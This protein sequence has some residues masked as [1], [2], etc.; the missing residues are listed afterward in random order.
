METKDDIDGEPWTKCKT[1]KL[2]KQH[3]KTPSEEEH[4]QIQ[5]TD[6]NSQKKDIDEYIKD[7]EHGDDF[8]NRETMEIDPASQEGFLNIDMDMIE[9]NPKLKHLNAKDQVEQMMQGEQLFS[10]K[11]DQNK[12]LKFIQ[13]NPS[14]SI[15]IENDEIS[16]VKK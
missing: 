9:I 5:F 11:F 1:K 16:F 4:T 13:N 14:V 2:Y 3:K 10:F 8:Y 12:M 15:R 6:L 7:E